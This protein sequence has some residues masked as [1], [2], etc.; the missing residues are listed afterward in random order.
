MPGGVVVA[1]VEEDRITLHR[2]HLHA[3]VRGPWSKLRDRACRRGTAAPPRAPERVWA[4]FCA[5]ST[6]R[7]KPANTTSGPTL[8]AARTAIDHFAEANLP[9]GRYSSFEAVERAALVEVGN[10]HNVPGVPQIVGE[11]EHP[12]PP[13]VCGGTASLQPFGCGRLANR[14][15]KRALPRRRRCPSR[16]RRTRAMSTRA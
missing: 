14:H 12:R 2:V 7:E 9:G 10:V 5:G 15:M 1:F 6:P 13:P 11:G 8:S 16:V 4:S 3:D